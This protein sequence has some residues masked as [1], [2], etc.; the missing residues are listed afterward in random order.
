MQEMVSTSDEIA[1]NTSDTDESA[2]QA[3]ALAGTGQSTVLT[4]VESVNRLAEQVEAGSKRIQRLE[5]E[6]GEIGNEQQRATAAEMTQNVEA[7]SGA[8]DKLTDDIGHV[9]K[10]S[11]SLAEMAE[12]LNSVVRRF[13]TST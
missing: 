8:I 11:K 5:R 2:R 3:A 6:S 10:S 9:N 12:D 4:A 1:S 7:S 13:K